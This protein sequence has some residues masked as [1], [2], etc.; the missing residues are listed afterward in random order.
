M[1]TRT[2]AELVIAYLAG[3]R[4]ALAGIYDR[5]GSALFDTAAAM[6]GDRHEAADVTQ[7]VFLVAAERLG[8]LRDPS[9]LKAWMFAVLRNEVYRRSRR[10][11]RAVPTDLSAPEVADVVAAQD[12]GADAAGASFAELASMVREAAR[13]LDER[14][15]LVLELSV[16]H[17]LHGADLAAAL[18][19]TPEQ[20]YTLVHRMRERVERSLTAFAVAR[21]GRRDCSELASIVGAD[22]AFTVLVRK[23]V[24]R[25]IE[26]C[27][28]CERSKHR[29]APL[30]LLSAAPVLAAPPWLRERVLGEP[31]PAT[32]V[33]TTADRG[34]FDPGDGFPEAFRSARR[35]SIAASVAAALVVVTAGVLIAAL[36]ARSGT[37]R[38]VAQ[39][40]SAPA[41]TAPAATV[42]TSLPASTEPLPT[43]SSAP[44]T[45]AS[46]STTSS[47]PPTV[48]LPPGDLTSAGTL[49]DLG[50][51]SSVAFEI[52]NTGGTTLAWS[53]EGDPAPMQ[54]TA[55]AFSIDPGGST[56]VVVRLERDGLAEG[57]YERQVRLVSDAAG[58]EPITL[59]LRARVESPPVVT[60]TSADPAR[61]LA[62]RWERAVVVTATVT[63]EGPITTVT[64]SW[65][66]PGGAGGQTIA[67][68]AGGRVSAVAAIGSRR[69]PPAAGD[70]T[71]TITA[72]DDRGNVGTDSVTV[73][74]L[75]C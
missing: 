15:Q 51:G 12:M 72:V 47:T 37:T 10:R 41:T 39:P 64:V 69:N 46:T 57:S 36:V 62:C 33:V 66:G 18:G 28:T 48:A 2:D 38:L 1:N 8:Q 20:S 29:L 3:E 25:H 53:V 26:R 61:Q 23:R 5:Y 55:G 71:V 56:A 21:G 60:I 16:R 58:D 75:A 65:A 44:T 40:V 14:D 52:T 13:G 59:T 17:G 68:V 7:D 27:E 35:L 74:A 9:R 73:T 54:V 49:V 70:W 45:S 43:T 24:A 11:R 32:S 6:L 42:A 4:D 31:A 30:T 67:S 22:A 34:G 19:V 63:D 50:L